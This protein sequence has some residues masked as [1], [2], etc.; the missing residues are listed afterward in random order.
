MKPVIAGLDRVRIAVENL[1]TARRSFAALGFTVA[2]RARHVGRGTGD[3]SVV[4]KGVDGTGMV[5][6]LVAQIDRHEE[7]AALTARLK[8]GEGMLALG[9][10]TT[11]A[12]IAAQELDLASPQQAFRSIDQGGSMKM[13]SFSLLDVL[14]AGGKRP[15]LE[16]VENLSPE[17]VFQDR[18]MRHANTALAVREI[19]I[20]SDSVRSDVL[21][22]APYT[23]PAQTDGQARA[24]EAQMDGN[25]VARLTFLSDKAWGDLYG[26]DDTATAA[27]VIE[28]ENAIT[29]K[30]FLEDAGMNPTFVNSRLNGYRVPVEKSHGVHLTFVAG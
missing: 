5:L 13:A 3:C 11:D 6:E 12:D 2:E 15:A 4:M 30:T 20:R 16:A 21:A 25:R 29:A 8:S 7:D 24:I 18:W 9:L 27:L 17:L 10:K 22:C 1:E 14:A 28:C 19:Q 23:C 26:K